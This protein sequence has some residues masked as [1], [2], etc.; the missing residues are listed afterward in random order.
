MTHYSFRIGVNNSEWSCSR[1]GNVNFQFRLFWI[2]RAKSITLFH[3]GLLQ[4]WKS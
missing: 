3:M 2:F 1:R 4:S